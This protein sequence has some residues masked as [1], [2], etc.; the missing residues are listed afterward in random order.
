M[1]QASSL[2]LLLMML[3]LMLMLLGAAET[4]EDCQVRTDCQGAQ[5]CSSRERDTGFRL[6]TCIEDGLNLDMIQTDPFYLL[7]SSLIAAHSV[8]PSLSIG[9]VL[10]YLQTE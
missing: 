1:T 10:S 6:G 3:M 8:F 9:V 5:C 4:A 2:L 7:N